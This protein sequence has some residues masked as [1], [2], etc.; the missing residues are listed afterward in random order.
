[1]GDYYFAMKWYPRHRA[2]AHALRRL[3]RAP[4]TRYTAARP[5]LIP[6][7]VVREWLALGIA[8]RR[9]LLRPGDGVKTLDRYDDLGPA[10]GLSDLE[11]AQ[12]RLG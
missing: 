9:L 4:L 5:W 11:S 10:L 1:V 7:L 6:M 12:A 3:V 8:A 2:A